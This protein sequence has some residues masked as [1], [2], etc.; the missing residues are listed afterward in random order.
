MLEKLGEWLL[1]KYLGEYIEGL[2]KN[3]LKFGLGS[4]NIV[5]ENLSLKDNVLDFLDLPITMKYGYLK[6]LSLTIPWKHLTSKPTTIKLEG[7]YLLASPKNPNAVI[8]FFQLFL[9]ILKINKSMMKKPLKKR[10]NRQNKVN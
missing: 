3:N 10:F 2:D 9:I 6:K 4:G 1:Q 5:L 8:F 7:I